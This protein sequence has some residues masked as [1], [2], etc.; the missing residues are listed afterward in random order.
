MMCSKRVQKGKVHKVY[1]IYEISSETK[2]S[3]VKEIK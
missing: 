1:R 3:L 2:I